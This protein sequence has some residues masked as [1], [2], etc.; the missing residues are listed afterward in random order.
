LPEP[1]FCGCDVDPCV[2][3]GVA[4][5]GCCIDADVLCGGSDPAAP[6]IP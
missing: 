4:P 1:D 5:E 2:Y 6:D 3:F